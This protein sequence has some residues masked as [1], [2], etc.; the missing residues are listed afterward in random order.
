MKAQ[1]AKLEAKMGRSITPEELDA[2]LTVHDKD[3]QEFYAEL[4]SKFN[5]NPAD[6]STI[7]A[8]L[9]DIDAKMEY[10]AQSNKILLD[11]LEA[12]KKLDKTAPD[13]NAKL[14]RI[15]ELLENFKFECNCK[16]DC[17]DNG[18]IHEGIIGIIE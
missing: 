11:I 1:I 18:K 8:L 6:F 17:D 2:I 15:I 14:D 3:N 10:Q 16:C 13:Y 7:E 9:A 5:V 4:L 12:V